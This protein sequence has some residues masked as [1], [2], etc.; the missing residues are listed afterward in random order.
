MSDQQHDDRIV[1]AL[2]TVPDA[3]IGARIGRTLVEERLAACVNRVPEIVSIYR[4]EGAIHEDPEALLL[5]KTVRGRLADLERRLLELH[6]YRV[7]EFV[8][9]DA[10][11][12]S[13]AYAAWLRSTA[14]GPKGGEEPSP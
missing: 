14:S 13:G 8:V 11:E 2:T 5:I 7:P 4:F 1:I 6:P 12:V 10:A 9:V 3:A